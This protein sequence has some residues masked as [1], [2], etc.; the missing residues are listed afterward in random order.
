M[1]AIQ[2]IQLGARRHPRNGD[3]QLD[4]RD[5][6]RLEHERLQHDRQVRPRQPCRERVTLEDLRLPSVTT[7]TTAAIR[8]LVSMAMVFSFRWF[9]VFDAWTDRPGGRPVGPRPDCRTDRTTSSDAPRVPL[10]PSNPTATTPSPAIEGLSSLRSA[11]K[12]SLRSRTGGV[13]RATSSVAV[14]PRGASPARHATRRAHEGPGS[15]PGLLGFTLVVSVP[16]RRAIASGSCRLLREAV[17]HHL[18]E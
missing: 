7:V 15:C 10:A 3:E 1:R 16:D 17:R 13:C 4:H 18:F 2:A 5:A 12:A 9:S 14:E 8:T 6:R 11:P